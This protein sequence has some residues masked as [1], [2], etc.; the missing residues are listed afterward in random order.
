VTRT[1]S[2]PGKNGNGISFTEQPVRVAAGG[3]DQEGCLIFADDWLV[4]VLVRLSQ[5]H[6]ALTGRWFLEAGFGPLATKHNM[7][8]EDLHDA[9]AW[10]SRRLKGDGQA[11]GRHS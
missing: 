6:E 2:S 8:F 1:L 9:E 3:G 7:I 11:G 4:A 5:A 10:I